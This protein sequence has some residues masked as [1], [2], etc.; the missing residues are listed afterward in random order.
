MAVQA[1]SGSNQP[2]AADMSGELLGGRW[3]LDKPL[4]EGGAGSVYVALDE[5]TH[6]RVAVKIMHG[7]LAEDDTLRARFGREA[8]IANVIGHPGVVRVIGDGAT[9]DGRPFLVMELLDGETLE[10]RWIRKGQKLAPVEVLWLTD[11]LLDVLQAAHAKGI[12]HRD[13]KPENLFLT[14]DRK[15][16]VLDFGI[17]RFAAESAV[18]RVGAVLGTL[19]FMAPEQARGDVDQVG[20]HTDLFGVGATMYALLSGRTVHKGE[21]L[22]EL[23]SAATK[24]APQSVLMVAPDVP[25][26]V[27]ELVDLALSFD[28]GRRWTSAKQ[29]QTAVR[30]VHEIIKRRS[31]SSMRA[32]EED[33]DPF[34]LT[35]LQMPRTLESV[36]MPPLSRV[37]PPVAVEMPEVHPTLKSTPSVKRPDNTRTWAIVVTI[38]ALV[39]A[40]L[41]VV[42]R[43]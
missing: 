11:L 4:G 31:S 24:R 26:P 20:V 15:L 39:A 30:E 3:R 23:L 17:A 14:R 21:T 41:L 9:R 43:R 5:K 28:I 25:P 37:E 18:T 27:A 36:E 2:N 40:A 19:D 29:M 33:E 34:S 1:P 13:I 10:A 16:K 35:P 32:F 38:I 8:R 22:N 12:V 7:A 42:L 6:D